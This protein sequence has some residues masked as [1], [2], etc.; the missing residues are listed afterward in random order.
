MAEHADHHVRIRTR[1]LRNVYKLVKK[2]FRQGC[3]AR[4]P[5]LLEPLQE[6]AIFDIL[7]IALCDQRF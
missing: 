7:V 5:V 3:A 6:S 1:D 2:R 4:T